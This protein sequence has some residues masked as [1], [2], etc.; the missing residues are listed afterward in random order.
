MSFFNVTILDILFMPTISGL[1]RLLI[2]T[3]NSIKRLNIMKNTIKTLS[4]ALIALLALPTF[5]QAEVKVGDD[6][7][8]YSFMD[9]TG[10]QHTVS[11]FAG[12]P[13]VFEWN[14][15]GCPF[16]VKHYNSQ[17]M[18]NTQKFT[19]EKGAIWVS[20]NSSGEGKE[21]Y[22]KDN[23]EVQAYLTKTGAMPTAYVL[24]PD[25]TIGKYFGATNT[26]QIFILDTN[27]KVAYTGAIDS[28]RSADPQDI[29]GA[30]NYVKEAISALTQ[31][32]DVAMP[33]TQPYGCSVKYAEKK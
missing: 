20:V 31:G 14:N 5:A 4:M 15:P 13:V 10:T 6:L 9:S 3:I 16:V 28:V 32:K 21:G 23:A 11:D 1:K 30:T 17:N 2:A 24:D 26:P 8:A 7:S 19:S 25:G 27:G 33:A 29:E 12:K 22:L 18:Q